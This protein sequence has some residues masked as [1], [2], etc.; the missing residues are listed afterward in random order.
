MPP[1]HDFAMV[2]QRGIGKTALL[3]WLQRRAAEAALHIVDLTPRELA[4][5]RELMLQTLPPTDAAAIGARSEREVTAKLGGDSGPLAAFV[6]QTQ[7][8]ASEGLLSPQ[9]WRD[10]MGRAAPS[11]C[12]NCN[13]E[14]IQH[15]V[16]AGTFHYNEPR[17]VD[18]R[19]RWDL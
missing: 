17:R 1:P 12:E 8:S 13:N 14:L 2:A 15:S 11:K 6:S 10:A 5:T 4:N 16:L 7:R 18:F 3:Q 19:A 9:A